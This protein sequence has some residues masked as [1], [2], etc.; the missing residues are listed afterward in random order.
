MPF[1]KE[2]VFEEFMKLSLEIGKLQ[3]QIQ[4]VEA[5]ITRIPAF[6]EQIY[7]NGFTDGYNKAMK[8]KEIKLMKSN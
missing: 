2:K 5:S 4:Q 6:F 1:E 7:N 3:G 8:E